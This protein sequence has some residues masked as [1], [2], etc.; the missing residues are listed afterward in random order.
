[1][2][3]LYSATAGYLDS[4]ILLTAV[5]SIDP[6]SIQRSVNGQFQP[7]TFPNEKHG[8][9]VSQIQEVEYLDALVSCVLFSVLYTIHRRPVVIQMIAAAHW[10]FRNLDLSFRQFCVK[11]IGLG[12]MVEVRTNF[13]K[14][15]R[16]VLL[17]L[18]VLYRFRFAKTGE[19]IEQEEC[20]ICLDPVTEPVLTRCGH[21]YHW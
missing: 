1:M 16:S 17:W 20:C 4:K 11:S 18:R 3:I 14:V 15:S 6:G 10:Q 9:R 12:V 21:V 5:V 19:I 2:I 8:A 13:V 7:D